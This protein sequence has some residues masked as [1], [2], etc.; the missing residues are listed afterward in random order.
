MPL[1]RNLMLT[2]LGVSP[3]VALWCYQVLLNP[4]PFYVHYFDPETIYF[5]GGTLMLNGLQP[6][7]VDNPGMPV[8]LLTA[9][10]QKV[11]SFGPLDYEPFRIWA[12]LLVIGLYGLGMYLLARML[13][14]DLP[15][16]FGFG[17]MLVYFIASE[18]LEYMTVWSPDALVFPFGVAL[19]SSLFWLSEDRNSDR[20][21]FLAGAVLGTCVSL[22][23]TFMSFLLACLA[24]IVLCSPLPVSRR[25]RQAVV[26]FIGSVFG[27]LLF[28]LPS[29]SK[30]DHM[31]S[32]LW[33][34]T[35]HEGSYGSG[36]FK[37]LSVDTFMKNAYQVLMSSKA[38]I[39][40]L[41]IV[42]SLAIYTT[43]TKSRSSDTGLAL[44]AFL[45][46]LFMLALVI[47]FVAVFRIDNANTHYL[48]PGAIAVVGLAL[49]SL[50]R[51]CL[52]KQRMM[53]T[54]VAILAAVLFAKHAFL[55]AGAHDRR[56]VEQ[57]ELREGIMASLQL[58]DPQYREHTVI[59]G[60]RMP[61]PS[62]ALR[63]MAGGESLRQI[64]AAFPR[65]G[66]WTQWSKGVVLPAGQGRWEFAVV[67]NDELARFPVV[68]YQ[69]MARTKGYVILKNTNG[70]GGRTS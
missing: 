13:P 59:Y 2:A 21:V 11:F 47:Q 70:D 67:R 56:I 37:V 30:V 19:L 40:V 63:A 22:K 32:R 57:Q 26:A 53:G 55:V 42:V 68:T 6:T 9:A 3:L 33:R 36:G 24:S 12:Y 15:V 35:T 10:V 5:H 66:H 16:G 7:N 18:S 50:R 58:V 64:S 61:T 8:Y 60:W 49:S 31:F 51:F 46:F 54:G 1:R 34:F 38:W 48:L 28:T 4:R 69:V 20:R 62:F 14:L 45:P 65:E 52:S 43:I 29:I 41:L 27:F 23:F 25:V 44:E 17:L 39:L